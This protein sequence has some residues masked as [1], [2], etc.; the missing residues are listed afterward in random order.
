MLASKFSLLAKKTMNFE[1]T[2]FTVF[3]RLVLGEGP[4]LLVLW[5]G[6]PDNPVKANKSYFLEMVE[7]LA[8]GAMPVKPYVT[9]QL[10][11]LLAQLESGHYQCVRVIEDSALVLPHSKIYKIPLAVAVPL[12]VAGAVNRRGLSTGRNMVILCDDIHK[13]MEYN[14]R[15]NEQFLK[16]LATFLDSQTNVTFLGASQLIWHA[17]TILSWE[18]VLNLGWD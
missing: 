12:A 8:K 14:K 16:E 17:K 5:G 18:R 4:G 15:E 11:Q 7:T 2:A 10:E 1:S 9:D 3:Q 6:S 13:F